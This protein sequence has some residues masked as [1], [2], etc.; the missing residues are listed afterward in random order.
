[1]CVRSIDSCGKCRLHAVCFRLGGG[2]ELSL[3]GRLHVSRGE[4]ARGELLYRCGQRSSA[5][6]A[7]RSGC[8]KDVLTMRSGAE[9]V[10]QFSLPGE[11]VGL[12]NLA[13][14][15]APTTA[16]AVAATQY[17][18][19]PL[20]SFEKLAREV[21][22]IGRELVRLLAATVTATRELVASVREQ[23]AL[24]R[25][26]GCLTDIS[27]RM[28]RAGLDGGR[29]RL[30]VS[31]RDLASYLGLTVE[32]VSR[33]LTELGRLRLIEVSAKDVRLLRPFEL[34]GLAR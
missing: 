20:A 28:R 16:I 17:C 14:T 4:L 27:G 30:G 2:R 7:L 21:P 8:V 11:A 33:C 31:R 12:G 3:V 32:T 18:R 9:A 22:E 29:F 5:V 26:A 15:R 10:L 25:V 13:I 1:M 24:A 6:Y 23:D 34:H 19:V